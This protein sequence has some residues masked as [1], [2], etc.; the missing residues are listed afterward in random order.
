MTC[1]AGLKTKDKIIIAGDSMGSNG[2]I[3]MQD[4]KSKVFKKEG[5]IFGGCGSYRVAQLMEYKWEIPKR[6]IGQTTDNYIFTTFTD[7]LIELFT[8]NNATIKKDEMRQ[9]E[10]SFL[11]GYEDE[12]Y[13]MH[14][15]FQTNI[16]NKAYHATGSGVYHA[17]SSLYSTEGLKLDPRER[18]KRAITCASEFVMSVDDKIDFVELDFKN[19]Q[20]EKND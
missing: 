13:E 5:F 10:G 15:N 18:L 19:N 8:K 20:K 12:L 4:K 14:G 3:Y 11:F 2:F 6:I 9:F 16:N 17:I 7:S 1:I